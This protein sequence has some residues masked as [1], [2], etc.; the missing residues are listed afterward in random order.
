VDID[1][2]LFRNIRISGLDETF[3]VQTLALLSKEKMAENFL[4]SLW[5]AHFVDRKVKI[6][7]E[8]L[9]RNEDAGLMRLV[10]KETAGLG[11]SEIRASLKRAV[12]IRIDF[13]VVP[14]TPSPSPAD[15]QKLSAGKKAA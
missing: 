15:G 7:V 13:P 14:V 2:K 12:P 8:G 10:R 4:T 1:E 6:A 5:T 3:A 11:P 9:F